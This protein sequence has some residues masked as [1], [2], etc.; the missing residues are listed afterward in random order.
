MNELEHLLQD[1][2]Y[3]RE[4][5]YILLQSKDSNLEDTEVIAASQMLNAVILKYTELISKKL[6]R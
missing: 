3:L 4:Q 5:L 2:N 6:N 1:I